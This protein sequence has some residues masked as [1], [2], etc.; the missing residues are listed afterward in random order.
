MLPLNTTIQKDV[1]ECLYDAPD[2]FYPLI[3]ADVPANGLVRDSWDNQW[4]NLYEYS[5]W[6]LTFIIECERTLKDTGSLYVHAWIGK[7]NP[8]TMAYL[9]EYVYEF[10]GLILQ[11]V[12]TWAKQRGNGN[13]KGWMYAR[14]ELLWLTK[15]E[16]YTWNVDY[17]YSTEPRAYE[18]VR[19]C[20]PV[21]KSPFKRYTNVWPIM[22]V[23]FG[24]SPRKAQRIRNSLNHSTPKPPEM[25]ERIIRVHT[26]EN[27]T[28]LFSN[29]F[30]GITIY[31]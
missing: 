11:D 18:I 10:T 23:G 17:Q 3:I 31:K 1:L 12:I 14:E 13:R 2:D 16:R 4:K 29:R 30:E 15:T 28:V 27:D 7:K 24:T 5:E 26:K 19:N 9:L 22:E 6:L 21:N 8:V 20:K 25:Y